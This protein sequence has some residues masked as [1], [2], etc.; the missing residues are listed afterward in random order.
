M[1]IAKV[2]TWED[3]D[4]ASFFQLPGEKVRSEL[5]QRLAAGEV[6][7]GS[8]NCEGFDPVKGCPGHIEMDSITQQ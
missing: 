3:K 6:Y 8:Q 4:L 5:E 2:L 7:I 1:G